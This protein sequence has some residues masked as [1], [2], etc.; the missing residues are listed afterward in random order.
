MKRK[1]CYL[2][3]LTMFI[4]VICSCDPFAKYDNNISIP[5]WLH[6]EWKNSN[7]TLVFS[8]DN[9]KVHEENYTLSLRDMLD[10]SAGVVISNQKSTSD[11]YYIVLM[12]TETNVSLSIEVN[13]IDSTSISATLSQNGMGAEYTY[14]KVE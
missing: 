9:L 7:E 11:M 2:L 8:A 12:N 4:I 3:V 10:S 13:K 1:L 5:A 14:T 6:G